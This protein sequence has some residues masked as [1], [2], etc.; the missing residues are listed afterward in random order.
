MADYYDALGVSRTATAE[1]VGLV[2]AAI[3]VVAVILIS[4]PKKA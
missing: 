2:V 3:L 1:Q 4:V